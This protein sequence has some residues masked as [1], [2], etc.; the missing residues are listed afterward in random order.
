[1]VPSKGKRKHLGV[2]VRP[3]RTCMDSHSTSRR[4]GFATPCRHP[5]AP[6]HSRSVSGVLDLHFKYFIY[7]LQ[8]SIWD[9][10]YV[11]MVIYVCY[12]SMSQ[13]FQVFQKYVSSVSSRSCICCYGYTRMFRAYVSSVSAFLNVCCK[14]FI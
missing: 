9:V 3:V 6:L 14:C 4:C 5:L 12:K 7:M 1:M 13:V 10:A 2:G 8:K 11:A